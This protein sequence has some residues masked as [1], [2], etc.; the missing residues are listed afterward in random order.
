MGQIQFSQ[1]DER[2]E[3]GKVLQQ[4][5]CFGATWGDGGVT[6]TRGEWKNAFSKAL[7]LLATGTMRA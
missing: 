5:L 3:Q 4:V 1:P 2:G 7:S 6:G